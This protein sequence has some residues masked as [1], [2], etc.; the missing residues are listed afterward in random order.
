MA[1]NSKL[2]SANEGQYLFDFTLRGIVF[3]I[4]LTVKTLLYLPHLFTSY[5]V[6]TK[7]LDRQSSGLVWITVILIV[8]YFNYLLFLFF[9]AMKGSGIEK[10]SCG[11]P[12]FSLPYFTAAFFL[13]GSS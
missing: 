13:L 3:F 9:K 7:L 6:A 1:Y 12:S 10:T 11:F 4:K 8:S 5:L 2:Y